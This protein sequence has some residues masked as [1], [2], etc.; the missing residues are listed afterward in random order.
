METMKRKEFLIPFIVVLT[1]LF[2]GVVSAA[3]L[4]GSLR[5]EFNSVVLTQSSDVVTNVGDTVPVRVTFVALENAED[6]RVN[7]RMESFR[8]DVQASSERF[9]IIAGKT[10]TKLLS[11]DIPDFIR[12]RTHDITFYVEVVSAVDRTEKTYKITLQRH[13]YDLSILTADF[14]SHVASGE[15]VPI[16]VVVKNTGFMR[17]DDIYVVATIPALGVTSRT[18]AGDLVAVEDYIGYENEKDAVNKIAYL[19][20]PNDA[21]SGAYDVIINVHDYRRDTM[22][23]IRRPISVQK[24]KTTTVVQTM[25]SKEIVAGETAEYELVVINTGTTTEIFNIGVTSTG[26]LQV[27]APSVVVVG[28]GQSQTVPIKVTAPADA[29]EGT[30]SFTIS[31]NG[32]QVVF[33][34]DVKEDTITTVSPPIV[35]LTVILVI[36][37]VVLL[38]VLIILLSRKESKTEEVETSY[39]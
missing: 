33:T 23:E 32:E 24:V 11:L 6:V 13:S 38:A 5:T 21:P 20:I 8:D 34:A 14:S 25:K 12:D 27:S 19:K 7:V 15:V 28:P 30:R 37:F 17:M 26:N 9:N 16:S 29:S 31:V 2:I 22:T 18:Y 10:Y 1:F 4:A 39:Y 36:I 35:A 3:E